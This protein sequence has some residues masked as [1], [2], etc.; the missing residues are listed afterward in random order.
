MRN[1]ILQEDISLALERA[2]QQGYSTAQAA[3]AALD[4]AKEAQRVEAGAKQ[5]ALSSCPDYDTNPQPCEKSMADLLK[6]SSGQ[7]PLPPAYGGY[8]VAH[9]ATVA[10]R[11]I[12]AAFACLARQNR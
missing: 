8:V 1:K 5:A 9:F 2:H 10:N 4:Q 6:G 3:K 7:G 12:A 11:E